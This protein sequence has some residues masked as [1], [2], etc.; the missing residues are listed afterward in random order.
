MKKFLKILGIFFGTLIILIVM[1][2]IWA[3]QKVDYTPYWETD[4]YTTTRASLDSLTG[5]LTPQRGKVYAGFSRVSITPTLGAPKDDPQKGAFKALPLAGFG[6]AQR[7]IIA[8]RKR[9]P[10]RTRPYIVAVRGG[11]YE[12]AEPIRFT[13]ADSGTAGSPTIFRAFGDE[14]PILSG[15]RRITR[16]DRHNGPV[17]QAG[18]PQVRTGEWSFEQLWVNEQRRFRPRLPKRGWYRVAGEVKPPSNAAGYTQFRYRPGDIDP[19]WAGRGQVEMHL[20][21][22]WSDSRMFIKAVDPQ[23]HIVTLAGPTR[24]AL[25]GW[26]KRAGLKFFA[27]A[28]SQANELEAD[29][30]AVRLMHAA[31]FDPRH[32]LALLRRLGRLESQSAGLLGQYLSS[33]PPTG[34]RL[35]EL[36]PLVDS[37]S[38]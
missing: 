37:L 4:Y 30:F 27:S 22:I 10:G 21:H 36:K 34:R 28:Y 5:N 20:M 1:L 15:G 35:A 12:L 23:Q 33:H 11:F 18:L 38:Q 19:A 25:G 17:W 8:L 16:W 24:G 14:R 3:L 9:Q 32:G 29:R 2:L 31:G 6:E 7:R 13:P 26:V